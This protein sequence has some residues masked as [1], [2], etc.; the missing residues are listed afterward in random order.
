M[1]PLHCY[2]IIKFFTVFQ[3]IAG[4]VICVSCKRKIKFEESGRRGLGFKIILS[5]MYSRSEINSGPLINTRFEINRRIVFVIGLL[6]IGRDDINVFCE[7][8]DLCQGLAKSTYDDIV[9]HIHSGSES[10]FNTVT[11]KAVKEEREEN[12]ENGSN[13]NH[14]K[15]SGDAS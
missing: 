8:M 3:A 7:L 6:G 15:V 13:E 11:E 9:Q 14:L 1:N 5:C 12:A 10:M 2:R 4:I